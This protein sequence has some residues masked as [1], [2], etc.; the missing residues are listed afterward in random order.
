MKKELYIN[1]EYYGQVG[2][3]VFKDSLG[4]QL[5]VGD[6]VHTVD[7]DDYNSINLIVDSFVYGWKSRTKNGNFERLSVYKLINYTQI[8]KLSKGISKN[9]DKFE[10][11]KKVKEMTIAEIEKQLG[12]PIKIVKEEE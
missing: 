1:G 4:K 11:K 8:E 12:Y 9:L 7:D 2:K 3:P 6:I 10:I 5:C